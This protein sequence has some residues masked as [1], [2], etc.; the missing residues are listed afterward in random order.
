MPVHLVCNR[1]KQP[2]THAEPLK[3]PADTR[4]LYAID[5]FNAA[6]VSP[7]CTEMRRSK[8]EKFMTSRK[9]KMGIV[10]FAPC[11]SCTQSDRLIILTVSIDRPAYQVPQ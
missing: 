4:N 5:A 8:N 6:K 7:A 3:L 11:K 2:A 9:A 10:S 1:R